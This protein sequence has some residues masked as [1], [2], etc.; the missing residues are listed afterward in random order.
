M[1]GKI[2]V[3]KDESLDGIERIF[4]EV[5][6]KADVGDYVHIT[7]Y[8]NDDVS[9]IGRVKKD[10]FEV[11]DFYIEH[12]SGNHLEGNLIWVNYGDSYK[13]LEPTDFVIIDGKLEPI[14]SSPSNES[15]EFIERLSAL[16]V[17]V[18]ELKRRLD[19]IQ[20]VTVDENFA[21]NEG[22]LVR[23]TVTYEYERK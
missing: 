14:E 20:S 21:E 22:S 3:I 9:T 10:A 18:A 6:R 12:I 11:D 7:R 15:D 23:K 17:E 1:N 2:H 8:D 19:E 5:E 4:V 13:T 16:A